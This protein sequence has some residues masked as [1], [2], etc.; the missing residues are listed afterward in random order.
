MSDIGQRDEQTGARP[1]H[2]SSVE[3]IVDPQ[4]SFDTETI[5]G[6]WALAN[7]GWSVSHASQE[8]VMRR[9]FDS[10][11]SSALRSGLAIRP[12]FAVDFGRFVTLAAES[13]KVSV[14]PA[15]PPSELSPNLEG[16][17][18][19]ILFDE[20]GIT[21]LVI[22]MTGD[23]VFCA[24]TIRL[25]TRVIEDGQDIAFA[26]IIEAAASAAR[27]LGADAP[28]IVWEVNGEW[29]RARERGERPTGERWT[30]FLLQPRGHG[31]LGRPGKRGLQLTRLALA[32][33]AAVIVSSAYL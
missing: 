31:H 4:R 11:L 2:W 19:C 30:R 33:T 18:G 13:Q 32:E 1:L 20:G 15:F 14:R 16:S 23:S 10:L 9:A 22:A 12:D 6:E 28:R 17:N 29:S 21:P 26:A 27:L 3:L 24:S 7:T 8:E 25:A 5:E